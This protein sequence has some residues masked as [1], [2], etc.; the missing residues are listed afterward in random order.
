[1]SSEESAIPSAITQEGT[2]G[3]GNCSRHRARNEVP[4]HKN[5]RTVGQAVKRFVVNAV[6]VDFLMTTC[7]VVLF[8]VC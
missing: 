8:L 6:K 2:V 5:L 7:A 1:M 3:L 4:K